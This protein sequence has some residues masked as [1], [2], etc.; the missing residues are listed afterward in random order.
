MQHL[1][2]SLYKFVFQQ[3]SIRNGNR[4]FQ[5]I[6]PTKI[7]FVQQRH[8][9]TS[10]PRREQ[11][12]D[13]AGGA[14]QQERG[15]IGGI[16]TWKSV[17]LMLAV[18]S[19]T[20][21]Y[22]DFKKAQQL[23]ATQQQKSIGEAAIGGPFNLVTHEGLP[24]SDLKFR[25]KYMLIYF[26]FT[27]CPDICPA[28]LKKLAA[29][30]DKLAQ[31]GLTKNVVAIFITIDPWRDT[32]A[33]TR[34]YVKEFY[35]D[36]VGLTGTPNQIIKLAKSY[37]VYVNKAGSDEDYLVDHSIILYLVGLDG[38]FISFYGKTKDENDVFNEVVKE[39]EGGNT[40]KEVESMLKFIDYFKRLVGIGGSDTR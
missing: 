20:W 31:K 13:A 11:K 7:Q 24:I 12:P 6:I 32:V 1:V 39:I 22:F 35:P 9:S 8:I 40:K 36:M 26:G 25:G 19:L 27:Y 34:A 14:S 30:M 29:V 18:G 4:L 21:L 37:R 28:E 5:R 38:K 10:I 17:G 2:A 3:P 15:P 23:A 16:I 33:Q